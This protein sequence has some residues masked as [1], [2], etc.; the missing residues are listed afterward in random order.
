M[1][2]AKETRDRNPKSFSIHGLLQVTP[3]SPTHRERVGDSPSSSPGTSGTKTVSFCTLQRRSMVSGSHAIF[4]NMVK[5][6]IMSFETSW[7]GAV[8]NSIPEDDNVNV[9]ISPP[10]SPPIFPPT[11]HTERLVYTHITAFILADPTQHVSMVYGHMYTY[12]YI[13]IC[14]LEIDLGNI[15]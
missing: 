9:S 5:I 14:M 12:T 1:H 13:Y 6:N 11:V 2:A 3:P 7:N 15:K 10:P 4:I 8:S